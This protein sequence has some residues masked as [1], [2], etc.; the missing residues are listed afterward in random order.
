MDG[1]WLA[2][3]KLVQQSKSQATSADGI[4]DPSDIANILP[5]T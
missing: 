3:K 2:V 1:F 4:T 5:I